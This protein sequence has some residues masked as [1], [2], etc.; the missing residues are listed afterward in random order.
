MA[1]KMKFVV[2]S[3]PD[4]EDLVAEIYCGDTQW[5]ELSREAG[6]F[7]LEIYPNPDGT[8]W[9][10]ELSSVLEALEQAR[11]RLERL[12]AKVAPGRSER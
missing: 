10:F 4:R 9:A 6:P 3:A 7:V 2:T 12:G 5:A 11:G 8:P 1:T